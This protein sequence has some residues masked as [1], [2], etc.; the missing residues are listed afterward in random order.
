MPHCPI[1]KRLA[2]GVTSLVISFYS[3][4]KSN[5][6]KQP[7]TYWDAGA[8]HI[9]L[10]PKCFGT[11]T[12]KRSASSSVDLQT[13]HKGEGKKTLAPQ[14]KRRT[15]KLS[16]SKHL[17]FMSTVWLR[18]FLRAQTSIRQQSLAPIGNGTGIASRE[19]ANK[20]ANTN[21]VLKHASYS[22]TGRAKKEY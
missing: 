13:G 2:K 22:G 4:G 10:T 12:F 16:R 5:E 11:F 17:I 3:T 8:R 9:R 19:G 6:K 15:A 1:P 7:L 21:A 20:S 18:W 14:P